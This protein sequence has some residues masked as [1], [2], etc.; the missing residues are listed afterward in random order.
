ME[1]ALGA[2]V[3]AATVVATWV[4]A[5]K[6][7]EAARQSVPAAIEAIQPDEVV[8]KIPS[9]TEPYREVEIGSVSRGTVYNSIGAIVDDIG[10]RSK[11]LDHDHYPAMTKMLIEQNVLAQKARG[12]PAEKINPTLVMPG[13]SFRIP[14]EFENIGKLVTPEKE[15]IG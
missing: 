3:L 2:G 5:P 1:H 6:A 12:V 11:S 10:Q 9:E 4:G 14:A 15:N 7:I 8:Y 13:D